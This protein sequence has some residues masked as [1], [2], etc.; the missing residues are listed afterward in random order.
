MFQSLRKIRIY[1]YYIVYHKWKPNTTP[2]LGR[3][4]FAGKPVAIFLNCTLFFNGSHTTKSYTFFIP[5]L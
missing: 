2:A 4:G 1:I 3:S 5:N